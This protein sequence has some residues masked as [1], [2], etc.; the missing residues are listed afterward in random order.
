M[1]LFIRGQV[2]VKSLTLKSKVESRGSLTRKRQPYPS[3]GMELTLLTTI[4]TIKLS[5]CF[6]NNVE[7]CCW[8]QACI[9]NMCYTWTSHHNIILEGKREK[10]LNIAQT[11]LVISLA[12]LL[13]LL[14]HV[15]PI[16]VS[17]WWHMVAFNLDVPK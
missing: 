16:N 11:T 12:F 6:S 5:R 15:P 7:K 9:R 13:L 2:L 3:N 17:N 8:L 10:A 14:E 4:D 1:W